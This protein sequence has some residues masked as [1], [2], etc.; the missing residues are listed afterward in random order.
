MKECIAQPAMPD[1]ISR[2]AESIR[3]RFRISQRAAVMMLLQLVGAMAGSSVRTRSP[4]GFYCVPAFQLALIREGPALI[5]GAQMAALDPIVHLAEPASDMLRRNGRRR[6]CTEIDSCLTKR[7]E[8]TATIAK[9]EFELTELLKPTDYNSLS[10]DEMMNIG[11]RAA[12]SDRRIELERTLGVVKREQLEIESRLVD[13]RLASGP[14][15]I[16][17]GGDWSHILTAAQ[18]SFDNDF[19]QLGSVD[20]LKYEFEALSARQMRECV[21]ILKRAHTESPLGEFVIPGDLSRV[22][23]QL[24]GT[25]TEF[26]QIAC[27]PQFDKSGWLRGF[28]FCAADKQDGNVESDA[29]LEFEKCDAW[30]SLLSTL[31][32]NRL[33]GVRHRMILDDVGFRQYLSFYDWCSNFAATLPDNQKDYFAHLPDLALRLATSFSI[34]ELKADGN[35]LDVCFVTRA[36]RVLKEY[37][38]EQAAVL[39]RLLTSNNSPGKIEELEIEKLVRRI[40][41]KQPVTMRTLVRSFN[42]Q[43]YHLIGG[44]LEAAIKEGR[45]IRRGDHFCVSDVSVSASAAT[46]AANSQEGVPS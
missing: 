20:T 18:S 21:N 16:R 13:L 8:I 27:N 26:S 22:S 38:G 1:L 45:V 9:I 44:R 39:G 11:I 32:T 2:C 30:A 33:C 23:M 28:L 43:D 25:A 12:R 7:E 17:D 34:I 42:V 15:I 14:G 40:R 31:L 41:L 4:N 37:A 19:L 10:V 35:L 29:I 6:T 3:R 46:S 5:H 36:I 24:T